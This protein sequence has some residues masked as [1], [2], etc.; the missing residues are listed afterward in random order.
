MLPVSEILHVIPPKF[1]SPDMWLPNSSDVNPVDY[2]VW[3]TMQQRSD[4]DARCQWTEAVADWD[5]AWSTA[6][7]HWWSHQWMART[8]VNLHLCHRWT[9][10]ELYLS[11]G[12]HTRHMD[13]S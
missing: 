3:R 10:W 2:K 4:N 13:C 5:K 12:L 8:S 1:I 11:F 6:D 7:S 9:F